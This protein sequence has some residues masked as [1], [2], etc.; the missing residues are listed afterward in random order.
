IQAGLK[1]LA[2]QGLP[3]FSLRG[4]A[5]LAGVSHAAPYRHF[6]DKQ[7]LV[8][9]ITER[10][11]HLLT[12]SM[13]EELTTSKT[14]TTIDKLYAI[15]IS[16]VRSGTRHPDYLRVIFD[17][18]VDENWSPELRE[19]GEEAYNVLRDVVAAGLDRGDLQKRD[20]NLVSLS[21]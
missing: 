14:T 12:A 5:Q 16:Y 17:G 19:A 4:A 21:Y 3:G 6:A 8:A 7:T 15:K 1:L 9:A 20:P 18:G 2:E 13:R 10:G 11:F